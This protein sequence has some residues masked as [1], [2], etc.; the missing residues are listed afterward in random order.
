MRFT[1]RR[2]LYFTLLRSNLL[3]H[4]SHVA[5]SVCLCV[6]VCVLGTWVSCAKTGNR[7]DESIRGR[8]GWQDGDAVFGPN[9]LTTCCPWAC[10]REL[11]R[12]CLCCRY[13]CQCADVITFPVVH[14][15][16]Y[17]IQPN[18][19]FCQSDEQRQRGGTASSQRRHRS[20]WQRDV[21]GTCSQEVWRPKPRP[22]VAGQWQLTGWHGNLYYVKRIHPVF[23]YSC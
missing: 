11:M 22:F 4:M 3:Q 1:N 5:W 10:L 19:G 17:R 20:P 9:S 13:S 23:L 15:R 14:C 12:C 2:L 8:E 6:S 18:F 16:R 21:T 7:S